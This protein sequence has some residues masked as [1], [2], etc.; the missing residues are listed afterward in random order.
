VESDP[1]G[2]CQLGLDAVI[3]QQH[4][5]VAGAR[6]LVLLVEARTVARVGVVE[7]PGYGLKFADRRSH[8]HAA[9]LELVEVGEALDRGVA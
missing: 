5:V 6:H 7:R 9:D 1:F 4:G 8:H 2:G 3:L